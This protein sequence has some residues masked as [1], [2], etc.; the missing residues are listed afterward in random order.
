MVDPVGSK[1]VA[2]DQ[3]VA[4]V[5]PAQP[6]AAPQPVAAQ[7][8]AVRADPSSLKALTQPAAATPPVDAERVSKIKKAI[9]DGKFP[10]VPSTIADRMLALKM[11]WKPG[12]NDA[13]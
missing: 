8:V 11:Q 12:G 9:E 1:P 4:P 2:F 7:E 5:A 3:R 13:A 6:V 10:L